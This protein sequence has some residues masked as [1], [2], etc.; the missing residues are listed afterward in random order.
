MK[1]TI[2][3]CFGGLAL[4]LLW[5]FASAQDGK[6][7]RIGDIGSYSVMPQFGEPY[8]NGWSLALE[9]INAA[10]GVNGQ[11]VA[12]ISRD[13]GGKPESALRHAQEL[14]ADQKVDVLAGTFLPG[15]ALAVSHFAVRNKKLFVA[16]EPSTD[17]ITLDRGNRYTF[18]LAPSTYMLAA[19]LAEEAIKLP[20][21]RWAIV[22]PNYEYGQS[23][24]ASFKLLLKARRPDVIFV[25]EQ[26]P[27][28]G[29]LKAE[30]VVRMLARARPEA[31]FNATSGADLEKFV[32]EG[33][34]RGL[35]E[36]I[37]VVSTL[38]GAP[39]SLDGLKDETLRDW[40][41][42]GY[43][44]EQINTPE[45][46][47]FM[48]AYTA[49]YNAHPHLAS[50]VGYATMMALA[51]GIRKAGSTDSEKLLAAMRGLRFG[52]PLGTVA[53]RALDQQ[54]TMGA[55]V[56][57]L[58]LQDGKAVMRRWRYADGKDYLPDAGYVR[59]RR[60]SAAMR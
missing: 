4:A 20:A 44:R 17:A 43:P 25:A 32:H 31:I 13:D 40:I 18:R 49:K 24:V 23:V 53:F 2:K 16:A 33:N 12:V 51:E 1:L 6:T 48:A 7:I 38:S 14:V 26:W 8:R 27:A 19:M 46:G 37:S 42:T 22:A 39:E 47:K 41:V 11:K 3:Q 36:K 52:T 35:F 28:L 5:S 15:T 60:P 56:G 30:A 55:Y 57:R 21:R 59:S 58:D 45:H 10:G 50:V 34:S 29:K 9:E 54:A